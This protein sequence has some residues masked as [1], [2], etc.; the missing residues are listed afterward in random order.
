LDFYLSEIETILIYTLITQI[1]RNYQNNDLILVLYEFFGE[2]QGQTIILR[3]NIILE[4]NLVQRPEMFLR[5][6][7]Q[8][9][10]SR[11]FIFFHCVLIIIHQT[12][13]ELFIEI[14]HYPIVVELKSHHE[15]ILDKDC[16]IGPDVHFRI[17]NLL[18]V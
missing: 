12:N 1:Y 2:I 4:L 10:S 7:L 8:N 5:A 17:G 13:L 14:P 18:A 16:R 6:K 3:Q 15:I 11:F 9:L